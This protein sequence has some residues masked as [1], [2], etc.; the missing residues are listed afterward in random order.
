[1]NG[2]AAPRRCIVCG[3]PPRTSFRLA[4]GV[5]LLRCPRC[6]LGWWDW[7]AFEPSAFYDRDYFQS[8]RVARGYDDYASLEAGL[9]RTARARLHRLARLMRARGR[10]I[11]EPRR[12]L[13]IGCGTG[14][15]LDEARRAGWTV[16]GLEVSPY[17]AAE[18]DRRD[19]FVTCAAVEQVELEP[20]AF[21]VVTLWDVLEHL[22]DP[23]AVLRRVAGA[24]RPGGVL[25]LS[26]GDVTSLCAR[27][28]GVRWHLFNL[29]EHLFFFSP[30]C[31]VR[32][33]RRVGCRVC[34]MGREVN[35][36]PAAY[37]LERVRKSL[38][39]PARWSRWAGGWVLP[40]TVFDVLGV[41]AIRTGEAAR[42]AP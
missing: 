22:R 28:S 41:Y 19:L 10:N 34:R 29:P 7:P 35:W 25:A 13:D 24:L 30:R 39:W 42:G 23:V 37:V 17:A 33:L 9:R 1:M 36:V 15:F 12:L 8:E 4:D 32:L 5:R 20:V 38:G 18:A 27:L 40:A 16:R 11:T 2:G 31:L 21:D 3:I 26:T 6:E 14:V